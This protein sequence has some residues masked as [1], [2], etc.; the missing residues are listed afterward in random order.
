M[1][2]GA[3]S[4]KGSL[5]SWTLNISLKFITRFIGVLYYSCTWLGW[6][7]YCAYVTMCIKFSLYR[8][9]LSLPMTVSRTNDCLMVKCFTVYYMVM[10]KKLHAGHVYRCT[11]STLAPCH[12][13]WKNCTLKEML[14]M[15]RQMSKRRQALK[16]WNSPRLRILETQR[17]CS[18]KCVLEVKQE[19]Q[20]SL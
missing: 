17:V 20:D 12:M 16:G 3:I 8:D 6:Y 1:S 15:D 11:C 5:T 7:K 2:I 4:T 19:Y 18:K 14:R 10:R 9:K 13:R